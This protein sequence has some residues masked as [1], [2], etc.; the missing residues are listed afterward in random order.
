MQEM[1][2][3]MPFPLTCVYKLLS[4]THSL[5]WHSAGSEVWYWR[6]GWRL[7]LRKPVRPQLKLA[8]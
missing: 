4:K 6:F 7:L 3:L 5:M 8:A 2:G 1:E